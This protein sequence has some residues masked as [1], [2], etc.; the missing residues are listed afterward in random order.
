MSKVKKNENKYSR[1]KIYKICSYKT[2]KIY[3]GSTCE[4]YLSNR[5]ARHR[6]CKREYEKN[7]TRYTTSFKILEYDDCEIVLIEDF[8]CKNK[9]QLHAR[10]RYWIENTHNCVNKYIPNRTSKEYKKVY[11]KENREKILAQKK[12]RFI[13]Q[14][15]SNV[16]KAHKARHIASK[17]HKEFIENEE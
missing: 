17:K 8:P 13:C 1:G 7:G 15:G 16:S 12:E 10:E 2:R 4:K 5:L 3:I 6:Q 14:C 9:Y 11:N